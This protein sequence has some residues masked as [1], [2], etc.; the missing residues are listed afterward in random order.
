MKGGK[1][2]VWNVHPAKAPGFGGGEVAE[3]EKHQA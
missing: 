3:L 2:G 1:K